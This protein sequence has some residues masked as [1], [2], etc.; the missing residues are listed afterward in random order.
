MPPPASPGEHG[1]VAAA[2]RKLHILCLHGSRQDGEVF[3]QRL[4]TLRKKLGAIAVSAAAVV[5]TGMCT[6]SAVHMRDRQHD[7]STFCMLQTLPL[8]PLLLQ[9]LHFVSAPHTLPLQEGQDVAMRAWWRHWNVSDS[10]PAALVQQA[11]QQQQPQSQEAEQA[12][13]QHQASLHGQAREA[14]VVEKMAA[15]WEAVVL[16]D[17]ATS[18]PLLCDAWQAGPPL[19]GSTASGSDGSCSSLSSA[20]NSASNSAADSVGVRISSSS[21]A[22]EACASRSARLEY[23]G[24]LGFSN[25]AAAAFL[26]AAHAAAHPQHFASLRFVALAGGYVP[27][28][29]D[30]L[31]PGPLLAQQPAAAGRA[32]GPHPCQRL[33]APLP[34]AS[35]HMMGSNDPL[36]DV[37]DSSQL[38]DCFQAHGRCGVCARACAVLC[39]VFQRA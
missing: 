27:E 34:F 13:L 20:S 38:M 1:G 5:R 16:R 39:C 29:L 37:G 31:L 7:P 18:L 8:L 15:G 21:S 10:E 23:D 28:P 3:S 33:A 32:G 36:M 26:F 9:E 12:Q 11:Q 25:G 14:E 4:K 24:V 19:L 2:Q 30:K 6:C 35:L 22:A 17:W